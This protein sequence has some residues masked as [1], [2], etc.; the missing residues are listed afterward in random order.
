MFRHF[1]A[2]VV[3]VLALLCAPPAFAGELRQGGKLLLTSGVSTVEGSA[4]GGLATWALIAGNETDAGIGGSAHAT[5]VALPD[6]D[7]KSV[8]GAIGLHN[9]VEFSYAHQSF[10]TRQAGATLG[11][12]RNFTFGQDVF[13]AKLRVIGDAVYD[14]DRVLPQISIGVQYHR[15]A[16]SAIVAAVGGKHA[17]GTDFLLSASKVVLA[18]SLVLGATVRF[19]KAN[20]FG[21]LGFGGDRS[22]AY[23]AEFEGSAGLLVSRRLLLGAEIRTKPDNL[24]F[25]RERKAVDAFAAWQFERHLTVT[26][27]Y[28]DLGSIA[29]FKRQRG[30]FLSL[31]ASF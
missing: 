21:L 9:R 13:G 22:D 7:L 1:Q 6:F 20:Q 3:C 28:A 17:Q 19:T 27:A 25:A 4:G 26:A 31:Q 14:Q 2:L 15:T 12:G 10:D 5:I 24:G 11:L 18:R 8:G 23:H 30:A 16:K 29:T